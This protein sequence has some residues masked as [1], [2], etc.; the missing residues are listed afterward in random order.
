MAAALGLVHL[1]ALQ[2]ACGQ[3]LCARRGGDW[4]PRLSETGLPVSVPQANY[5]GAV[6]AQPLLLFPILFP[7]C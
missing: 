6:T 4:L 7:S 5:V 1:P 2:A 3:A